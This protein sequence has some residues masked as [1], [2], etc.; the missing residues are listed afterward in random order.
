MVMFHSYVKLPED[1]YD[2]MVIK[3]WVYYGFITLYDLIP[4]AQDENTTSGPIQG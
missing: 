2:K 1:K 4:T 3:C